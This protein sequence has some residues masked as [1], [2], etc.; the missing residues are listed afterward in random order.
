MSITS[1]IKSNS[2]LKKLALR[3]LIPANQYKPRLWVKLILNPFKHKKGRG[4]VI[5]RRTRMDLFP[6]HRF[7]LGYGSIVED[8]STINNGVG[9]VLIGNKTIIG[10]ANTLIGPITI[11]DDVM[12]AQNIVVSALNHAYQDVS[13]SPSLQKVICKPIVISDR[14]WIGANCIITAGV[15][16][17]RHCIIGAGSVVTKDIPDYSVAVG[18]P[19]KVVKQ[20]NSQTAIWE[21]TIHSQ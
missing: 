4:S 8:F 18:N 13:I 10:I 6:H 12:L 9:D 16:L 7:E 19:A 14:V 20:Y 1:K 15:R 21:N 3:M 17:G 11:G 5:Q 2:T